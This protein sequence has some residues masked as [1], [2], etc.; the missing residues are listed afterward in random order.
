MTHHMLGGCTRQD[1]PDDLPD[2]LYEEKQTHDTDHQPATL[3]PPERRQVMDTDLLVAVW[4]EFNRR[5]LTASIEY[6]GYI[7]LVAG[8][9][10]FDIGT[11]NGNWGADL[12]EDGNSLGGVEVP[13]S[14]D[15]TDPA[16]IVI[17][18]L[19]AIAE[20]GSK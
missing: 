7:A 2:W 10:T 14:A 17:A 12:V 1:P 13:N 6:P 5:G 20:E 8:T 3:A 15:W 16:Q 18:I 9:K 4:T 19:A 11:A